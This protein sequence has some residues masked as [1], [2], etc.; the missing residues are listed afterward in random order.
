MNAAD[1]LAHDAAPD[2]FVPS[3]WKMIVEELGT[4]KRHIIDEPQS[5]RHDAD[6]ALIMWTFIAPYDAYI[7]LISTFRYYT[8]AD[9]DTEVA[10]VMDQDMNGSRITQGDAITIQHFVHAAEVA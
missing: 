5:Y 8:K 2:W 10:L 1:L 3:E 9:G 7:N 4:A 6:I